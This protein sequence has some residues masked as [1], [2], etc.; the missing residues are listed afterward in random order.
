MRAKAIEAQHRAAR[1]RKSYLLKLALRGPADIGTL[2]AK[3][4]IRQAIDDSRRLLRL[5]ASNAWGRGHLP[6]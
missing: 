1:S 5:A 3:A 4:D 2:C 6:A